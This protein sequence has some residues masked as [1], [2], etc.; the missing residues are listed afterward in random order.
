MSSSDTYHFF[1]CTYTSIYDHLPI[2]ISILS[3]LFANCQIQINNKM[4]SIFVCVVSC[5]N[6]RNVQA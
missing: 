6:I 5:L 1:V 2:A 4:L 3:W